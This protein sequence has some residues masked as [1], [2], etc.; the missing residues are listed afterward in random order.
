MGGIEDGL[1]IGQEEMERRLADERR[2]NLS[3]S[4]TLTIWEKTSSMGVF[5]ESME[6]WIE[7]DKALNAQ[8]VHQTPTK[9]KEVKNFLKEVKKVM[10]RY[11]GIEVIPVRISGM[12]ILALE[13]YMAE[14][15]GRVI[16]ESFKYEIVKG[17][18]NY[19]VKTYIES[20]TKTPPDRRFGNIK[21]LGASFKRGFQ[22]RK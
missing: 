3:D 7:V 16:D 8:T 21:D 10:R 12:D 20:T 11:E 4:S 9:E 22:R 2:Q 15:T 5:V 13:S 18:M 17:T 1:R 6:R 19:F 14:P